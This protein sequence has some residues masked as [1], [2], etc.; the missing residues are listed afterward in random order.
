MALPFKILVGNRAATTGT[1][2]SF[3][4]SLPETTAE[5]AVRSGTLANDAHGGGQGGV[6]R[7]QEGAT[8]MATSRILLPFALKK[9]S[10]WRPK[11]A[12]CR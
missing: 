6:L 5:L 4:V 8:I 12:V 3:Q 11:C 10:I 9:L 2:E 7:R 1:S